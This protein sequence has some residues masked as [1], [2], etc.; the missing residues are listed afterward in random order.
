[1]FPRVGQREEEEGL[2]QLL[3]RTH[4]MGRWQTLSRDPLVI[5]DTGHN[6][7]AFQ[8]IGSQLND[9]VESGKVLRI[10]IGM[11]N[12]KDASGVLAFL[13]KSAHY[14]FCQ[15]SV[16]RALPVAQ[17]RELARGFRL[18]GTAYATVRDAYRAAAR[19]TR[20]EELLFVGGSTYV[21]S[22]FFEF[23]R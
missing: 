7:D 19:E 6:P 22:D 1:M 4:L 9:W 10:V 18:E 15:P 5:C 20:P 3:V 2:R 23:L 13:P 8:Y 17:L 16:K 14:Y 12:D 11:V 21:V